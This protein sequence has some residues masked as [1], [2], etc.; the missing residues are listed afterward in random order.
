MSQGR[1][2]FTQTASQTG[3]TFSLN[4]YELIPAFL[5]YIIIHRAPSQH[6]LDNHIYETNVTKDNTKSEIHIQIG[7]SSAERGLKSTDLRQLR[8]SL[9][10]PRKPEDA[11]NFQFISNS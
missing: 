2:T 8:S 1:Q 5:S 11:Y 4:R 6:S 3:T 7:S 9:P 10:P